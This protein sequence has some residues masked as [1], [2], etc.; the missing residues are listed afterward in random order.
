SRAKAGS[1]ACNH[2]S[3]AAFAL[4]LGALL[5]QGSERSR[6]AF[7]WVNHT[8]E[9]LLGLDALQNNLGEAESGLRGFLLTRDDTYLGRFDLNL[10]QADALSA[11]LR[12]LVRDNP[13]QEPRAARLTALA[14][15]KSK[16]MRGAVTH[17]R[18]GPV[19]MVPDARVRERGRTLMGMVA[20]QVAEMQDAERQLLAGRAATAERQADRARALLLYGGPLLALLIAGLAWLIRS[21][22]S[23]PLADLLDV[24]TRFGAGDRNARAATTMQSAEFRQL[25][26]AYNDMAEHL[27]G[28]M[29]QQ[30]RAEAQLG[31]ANAEL[32]ER[33]AALEA[34]QRSVQ[35]LSEMSHRL[36]AIQ[37]EGELAAV[38][39]CFL[40]Q[41]LPDLAGA[42][43]VHN[44]SRNMLLR[45]SAWGDPEGA[46]EMF[47]PSDCW[48]LRRGKPHSVEKPGAD[49][50]CAHAVGQFANERLCQPVLAG[51]EVLGLLYIEGPVDGEYAFRLGILM[52]NVALALVNENLRSRL[53]EQSIRDPLT[54]LFNRRY[55]EEALALE[56]ARVERSGTD[57]SIVMCDVDHFK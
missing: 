7:G 2:C 57:L 29:D 37:S 36:Q 8:Q 55:M 43:Y 47:P 54:K 52:E 10:A 17:A 44:H 51:G 40:P 41:I 34:R 15:A 11:R 22:I 56:T 19:G 6:E 18:A 35:L 21:S 5:L 30:S 3:N 1:R 28:A 32:I 20:R 49:L 27:V 13:L 45:V 14:A 23:Q 26:T 12:M 42:L 33:G 38:L 24:V 50:V 39:D 9:V 53:R 25:A 46:P 4:L 31:R 16:I 48:G